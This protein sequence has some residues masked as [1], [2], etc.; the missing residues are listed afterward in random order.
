MIRP[1]CT[2]TRASRSW[3]STWV[4]RWIS[5]SLSSQVG[6]RAAGGWVSADNV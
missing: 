6:E 5:H 4:N 1:S 2:A 3:W